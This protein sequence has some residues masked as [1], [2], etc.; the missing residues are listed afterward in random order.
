[1]KL[2][3][4]LLISMAIPILVLFTF[5]V[6]L[7]AVENNLNDELCYSLWEPIGAGPGLDCWEIS[8][9]CGQAIV[10]VGAGRELPSGRWEEWFTTTDGNFGGS[11]GNAW[12][13][14]GIGTDTILLCENVD[15]RVPDLI[16]IWFDCECP[17]APAAPAAPEPWVRGDR[18]MMCSKVWVNNDG[19]F[20]LVFIYE[21]ADN[22]HVMIYDMEGNLVYETNMEYQDAHIEVCLPDG[23]YTVKTYHDDFSEPLQEFIIGKPVPDMEM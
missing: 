4:V 3:K 5:P 19:C 2:K 8:S 13:V 10:E 16:G 9:P 18:N 23:M 11:T 12:S 14:T 7:G 20:E 1:M 17:S 22:N 15:N 6:A 21:Y